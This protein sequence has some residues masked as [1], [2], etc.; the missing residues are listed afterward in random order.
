MAYITL[1]ELKTALNVGDLYP[2]ET[3]DD[4]IQTA[5]SVLEP[6]LTTKDAAISSATV[7]NGRITFVT[8]QAHGF[9]KDQNIE[10][11][12]TDYDD[13]YTIESV[14]AYTIVV[15][16]DELDTPVHIY[17]PVGKAILDTAV[18]YDNVVAVR[19][20]ALMIAVDIFNSRTVPGGQAQG[21]DFQP[22]P[23]MMGQSILRRVYGLLAPYRDVASIIG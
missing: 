22:G 12:G 19:S 3:L 7:R 1:N 8:L 16:T 6:F 2:D 20:A 10:I 9:N 23:Y 21:V 15:P 11:T 14:T 4:V 18:T 5:E 13:A 17:R